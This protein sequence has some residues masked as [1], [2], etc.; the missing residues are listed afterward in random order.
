MERQV[1]TMFN[2]LPRMSDRDPDHESVAG[3]IGE[4]ALSRVTEGWFFYGDPPVEIASNERLCKLF[5]YAGILRSFGYDQEELG[6]ALQDICLNTSLKD[7]EDD[8]ERVARPFGGRVE[9]G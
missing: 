2:E 8:C 9:W 6:D 4:I 1:Q 3:L 7:L 5:Y